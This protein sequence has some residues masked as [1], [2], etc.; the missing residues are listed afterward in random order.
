MPY[1]DCGTRQ[2]LDDSWFHVMEL[3]LAKAG[4]GQIDPEAAVASFGSAF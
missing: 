3:R 1:P 2:P 4:K